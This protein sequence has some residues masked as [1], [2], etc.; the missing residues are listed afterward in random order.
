MCIDALFQRISIFKWYL[1]LLIQPN[2]LN[3]LS[4]SLSLRIKKKIYNVWEESSGE[5]KLTL[6][7][8]SNALGGCNPKFKNL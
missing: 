6:E 4:L 1:L 2:H 3:V 8:V 7:E 5:N